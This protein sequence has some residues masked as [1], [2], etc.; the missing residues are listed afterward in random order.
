MS[1]RDNH[2]EIRERREREKDRERETERELPRGAVGEVFCLLAPIALSSQQWAGLT[3]ELA[4]HADCPHG[5]RA[6]KHCP[7]MSIS[8]RLGATQKGTRT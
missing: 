2:R 8:R 5:L 6:S 1:M 7:R 4:L 3:Q